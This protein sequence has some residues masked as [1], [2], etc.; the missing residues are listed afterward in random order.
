MKKDSKCKKEF[1]W[2]IFW[3]LSESMIRSLCYLSLLSY[4]VFIFPQVFPGTLGFLNS[5]DSGSGWEFSICSDY[6]P[7]SHVFFKSTRS[8]C[9]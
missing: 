5:P 4:D 8:D 9:N 2:E 7:T 6:D 1:F 3:I